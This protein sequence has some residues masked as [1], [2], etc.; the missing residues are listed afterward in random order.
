MMRGSCG[1]RW[2]VLAALA[3]SIGGCPPPS[4]V[5]E[6]I[7]KPKDVAEPEAE[8]GPEPLPEPGPEP[9]VEVVAEIEVTPDVKPEIDVPPK[10]TSDFMCKDKVTIASTTCQKAA[11]DKPTGECYAKW[12]DAC[13]DAASDCEDKAK[14]TK[15]LADL[16]Q[17]WSCNPATH[18]CEQEAKPG[19]CLDDAGCAALSDGCCQTATCEPSTHACTTKVLQECCKFDDPEYL[20]QCNDADDTTTDKCVAGCTAGGC[21][22]LPSC[23]VNG[24]NKVFAQKDF[25]DGTLQLLKLTDTDP[26]DQVT[27][28]QSDY[29]G[30]S[31]PWSL[32]LGH[33]TCPNPETGAGYYTGSL[34]A[35][36]TP[37]D[38]FMQE[39]AKGLDIRLELQEIGLDQTTSAFLGFW[40]RM[41]AEEAFVDASLGVLDFDFLEVRVTP[42]GGTAKTVWR[43]TANYA[44]GVKNTTEGKWTYQVVDLNEFK[45]QSVKLSFRFSA[46]TGF[47]WGQPGAGS[48]YQPGK[49]FE[50][51]YLDDII[52]RASCL[53][54]ACDAQTPCAE[55]YDGCTSAACSAYPTGGA[56]CARQAATPGQSCLACVKASDCGTDACFDYACHTDFTCEVKQKEECCLPYAA[57]P[58]KTSPGQVAYESFTSETSLAS[59]TQ[60][61]PYPLD[62]VRWQ[63]DQ[64][65]GQDAGASSLYFGNLATGNYD[66]GAN[67]A[68]S[69][70]WTK[71]IALDATDQAPVLSFWLWLS[72]EYDG[73]GGP[74]ANETYDTLSVWVLPKYASAPETAWNS[75]C[76]KYAG[77]PATC[78]EPSFL[79]S[80][81]GAW[82][83]AGVD[84]SKW[85]GQKVQIGFRFDSGTGFANDNGGAWVDELAV[86]YYC[87]PV[88]ATKLECLAEPNCNKGNY[89][90]TYS[91][92]YGECQTVTRPATECCSS[93][94]DCQTLTQNTCI[95]AD[96]DLGT[97]LCTFAYTDPDVCG[98]WDG[99]EKDKPGT[100][101]GWIGEW[102]AS[103]DEGG[104][105]WTVEYWDP[106]AS[107]FKTAPTAYPV[108]WHWEAAAGRNETGGMRFSNPE[109]GTYFD[110]VLSDA[111][112]KGRLI[113]PPITVPP[114]TANHYAEFW[115]ALDTEWSVAKAGAFAEL[116]DSFIVDE[117]RVYVFE[118]GKPVPA[119][120]K[121]RWRSHHVANTT[122]GLYVRSR[123]ALSYLDPVD[124]QWGDPLYWDTTESYTGKT[125]RLAFEFNAGSFDLN[126]YAGAWLDEVNLASECGNVGCIWS[127]P[128]TCKS[129][130]PCFYPWCDDQLS[131]SE[132][133][134]Q[135][136]PSCCTATTQDDWTL[137]F[138]AADA[139]TE[140]QLTSCVPEGSVVVDPQAVWQVISAYSLPAGT[141]CALGSTDMVLYFGNTKDY[142]GVAGAASCGVALGPEVTL[143]AGVPWTL[144]LDLFLD[145][146]PYS[147]KETCDNEGAPWTDK[148]KIV[149]IKQS[150]LKE[151]IFDN[152]ELGCFDYGTCLDTP[153]LLAVDLTPYAGQTIRLQ[154]EFDSY[155]A[156]VNDGKGIVV[157]DIE[158]QRGCPPSLP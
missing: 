136:A 94:T 14:N 59:W 126:G 142:G 27:W 61:D 98:C 114:Y 86:A 153:E 95:G 19:C 36:C 140:W 21:Q 96:C 158:F 55:D 47:N 57:F 108:A 43:S 16:C 46:D 22:Y 51:V 128:N 139:A 104:D 80:T 118:E 97:H 23:G 15:N 52:V 151:T 107:S 110:P 90:A 28:L 72:T 150:G 40:L 41:S 101:L 74:G 99:G 113:S 38:P 29:T 109:N 39:P 5:G 115:Y 137:N 56:V 9:D 82:K 2:V 24:I 42:S 81:G 154:F 84:L 92:E 100:V 11:C 143:E 155:D 87:I 50:G 157:D 123:V 6:E 53:S 85:A 125:V 119:K 35:D 63:L 141:G 122:Y 67:P 10:C 106:A 135:G 156:V 49:P 120:P 62:A 13:C 54:E 8:V 124:A 130:D 116:G 66:A 44:L 48:Q 133:F 12:T 45:G 149:V 69:T 152:S 102:K 3:L 71:E 18:K 131:C 37:K 112:P 79:N 148:F 77:N 144:Y 111:T 127:N 103:F 117:L 32:H 65:K 121:P 70:I 146:E 147:S 138:Q 64:S 89:C 33:A 145:T 91:C 93:K 31:T 25:D 75:N 76:L 20:Y 4:P 26:T 30:V 134:K 83:Q 60:D 88:G 129:Q 17:Q 7:K 58:S 68:V 34:N 132:V 105:G 78:K 73:T 1:V